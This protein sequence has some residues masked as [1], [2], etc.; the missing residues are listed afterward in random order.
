[1]SKDTQTDKEF[2]ETLRGVYTATQ[3]KTEK[4]IYQAEAAFNALNFDELPINE[5]CNLIAQSFARTYPDADT[6]EQ[7]PE[8]AQGIFEAFIG[9]KELISATIEELRRQL[10][11]IAQELEKPAY[12]GLTAEDAFSSDIWEDLLEKTKEARQQVAEAGEAIKEQETDQEAEAAE[13]AASR[14]ID[15]AIAQGQART[16]YRANNVA[17]NDLLLPRIYSQEARGG[18]LHETFAKRKKTAQTLVRVS[19]KGRK[20]ITTSRPVTEYEDALQT[21]I[22]SIALWRLQNG[23]E[24]YMTIDQICRQIKGGAKVKITDEDRKNAAE[25]IETLRNLNVYIDATEEMQMRGV[26]PEGV[27]WVRSGP[28]LLM[29]SQFPGYVGGHKVDIYEFIPSVLVDYSQ[30]NGHEIQAAAELFD[31][32]ELDKAGRITENRIPD[33]KMRV[34][35]RNYL[36]RRL[37]LMELDERNAREEYRKYSY[38]YREDQKKPEGQR[39]NLQP[40]TIADFRKMERKR[41]ILFNTLYD[42]LGITQNKN[43][44]QK[45]VFDVLDYWTASSQSNLKSYRIRQKAKSEKSKK[46]QVDAVADFEFWKR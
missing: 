18:L 40:K 8:T 30:N 10:G 21:A 36:W 19:I 15:E 34:Q 24:C 35:I 42:A 12:Q 20:D 43:R 2:I 44:V 22:N 17:T 31:I 13:D 29:R 46:K 41:T 3:E 33:S 11:A 16:V 32:H 9:N 5:A 4:I 25:G 37:S 23:L 6:I 26:V 27:P 1:M 14:L 7:Q 39:E 45:Y 38:R 28:V